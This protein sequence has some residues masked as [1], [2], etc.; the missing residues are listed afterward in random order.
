MCLEKRERGPGGWRVKSSC[1]PV[2]GALGISAASWADLT[3]TKRRKGVSQ[4]MTQNHWAKRSGDNRDDL[5][6]SVGATK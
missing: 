4:P 3:E 6:E 1:P 2:C 5:V